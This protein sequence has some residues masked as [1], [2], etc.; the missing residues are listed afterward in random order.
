MLISISPFSLLKFRIAISLSILNLAFLPFGTFSQETAH[1]FKI[2]GERRGPVISGIPDETEVEYDLNSPDHLFVSKFNREGLIQSKSRAK[3]YGKRFELTNMLSYS[4]KKQIISD[5]FHINYREDGSVL[6]E[7]VFGEDILKQETSY[8]PDGKKQLLISGDGKTLEGDYKIW[9]PDGQIYFSGNYR[10]NLKDGEFLEFDTIGTQIR[11]GIY[12]EGKLISGEAVVQDVIHEK[13]EV[14]AKYING[15]AEFD[16]YLKMRSADVNGFEKVTKEKWVDLKLIVDKTGKISNVEV[17]TILSPEEL[18]L[19]NAVL[20]EMPE[21]VPATVENIP[22]NS[23]IF[24]NLILSKEG[25]R[26]NIKDQFFIDPEEKPIF[27]G[28]KEALLEYLISNIKYPIEAAE[29]GIQGKVLVTF[30]VNEDGSLTEIKVLWGVDMYL[31]AEAVR[32]VRN[33]PKWIPG[34]KDGKPAKGAYTV[35]INFIL[36]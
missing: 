9:Y 24:L 3:F 2:V 10:G 11:K 35:P 4:L 12:Q 14:P 19:L 5:G 28:G 32:V 34:K 16:D 31:D 33:M 13:P 30:I 27:P 17:V 18:D 1:R 6:N 21:Y 36:E 25:L 7:L 8:Y 23:L 20:N 26:R 15:N 22:V 29:K